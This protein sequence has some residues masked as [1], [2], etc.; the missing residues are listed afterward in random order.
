M[1]AC[2][3]HG[4]V[5]LNNAIFPVDVQLILVQQSLSMTDNRH[6]QYE[7]SHLQLGSLQKPFSWVFQLEERATSPRILAR[8][9]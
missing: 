9:V 4:A 3:S 2:R 1:L 6:L 8:P 5:L 7:F